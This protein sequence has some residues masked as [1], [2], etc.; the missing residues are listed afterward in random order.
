MRNPSVQPYLTPSVI[1]LCYYP[2]DK[3]GGKAVTIC[4]LLSD[5]TV[6]PPSSLSLV[7][8]FPGWTAV[9]GAFLFFRAIRLHCRARMCYLWS[10]ALLLQNIITI[11]KQYTQPLYITKFVCMYTKRNVY[12]ESLNRSSVIREI[13][14]F[15]YCRRWMQREWLHHGQSLTSFQFQWQSAVTLHNV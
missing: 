13:C 4:N 11:G 9:L 10:T 15:V 8:F 6:N 3:K 7:L 1:Y 5:L 2:E 14:F 12:R